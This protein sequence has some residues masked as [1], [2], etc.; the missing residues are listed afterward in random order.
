M[1]EQNTAT[2]KFLIHGYNC[3]EFYWKIIVILL[4]TFNDKIQMNG[5]S[6]KDLRDLY[7]MFLIFTE[8]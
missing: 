3:C 1:G 7:F 5:K 8:S 4:R 6:L 2:N